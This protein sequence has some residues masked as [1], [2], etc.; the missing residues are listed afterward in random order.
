MKP[1][2]RLIEIRVEFNDHSEQ[3]LCDGYHSSGAAVPIPSIGDTFQGAEASATYVV[4]RRH[5]HIAAGRITARI[6]GRNIQVTG[7]L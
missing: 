1:N 3:P 7:G 6:Y 2:E 5:F 4:E